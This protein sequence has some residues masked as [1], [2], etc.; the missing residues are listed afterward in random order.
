VVDRSVGGPGG[1]IDPA[2]LRRNP[3]RLTFASGRFTGAECGDPQSLATLNTYLASH[4]D[5]GRVGAV[6]LPTNYLVR[7]EIGLTVQDWLLPGLS[8]Y[9]GHTNSGATSAPYDVP[10]QLRF[11]GRKQ[12]VEVRGQRV[13]FAGRLDASLVEGIDPF[14]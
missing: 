13:V 1:W 9:L 7:S 14:R 12:T 3:L 8:V 11:S 6:A 4:A 10:V 5:A 2:S